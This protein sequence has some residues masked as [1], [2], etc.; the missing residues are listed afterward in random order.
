MKG[1]KSSNGC[2]DKD[3]DGIAD[4]NDKCPTKAGTLLTEGCPDKDEDGVADDLDKCPSE[5][6]KTPTMGCPDA[7]ADGIADAE[8]KCPNQYGD[9]ENAGCPKI[10]DTDKDGVED[11]KD[12]CPDLKGVMQNNGCPADRDADGVYDVDDKCPDIA[13]NSAGCPTLSENDKKI[14]ESALYGVQFETAS[15]TIKE[16]SFP[17]LDKVTEILNR[18]PQ[19]NLKI[20]G[21]TDDT[22]TT[23]ENIVLSENRAKACYMY[24]VN[25]GITQN[26]ISYF[27]NFI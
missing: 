2:P 8:D 25:H 10:V 13:G 12:K 16:S 21:H 18:Y 14:L 7:D 1:P 9:K 22:G 20:N 6:G 23:K 19:Y 3:G 4:A 17:V 27:L 24:L 11:S 15:A 5:K 26:R